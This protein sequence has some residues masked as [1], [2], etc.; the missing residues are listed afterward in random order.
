[1]FS[2]LDHQDSKPKSKGSLFNDDDE[3]RSLFS[4]DTSHKEEKKNKKRKKKVKKVKGS[5]PQ[6]NGRDEDRDEFMEE[7]NSPFRK[8]KGLFS[9]GGGLFDVEEEEDVR[10]AGVGVVKVEATPELEASITSTKS[11]KGSM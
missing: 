6:S 1:M 4:D 7:E 9:G 2:Y 5:T 10:V 8:S 3:E 11:G